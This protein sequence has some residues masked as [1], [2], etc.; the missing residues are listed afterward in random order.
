M[1]VNHVQ[2]IG[3]SKLLW[4]QYSFVNKNAIFAEEEPQNS[5]EERPKDKM[6]SNKSQSRTESYGDKLHITN[7]KA[8]KYW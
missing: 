3:D 1:Q 8:N 2:I 6:E 7:K 4:V 5:G